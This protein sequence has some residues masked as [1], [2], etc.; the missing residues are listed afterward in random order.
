MLGF[1]PTYRLSHI[2]FIVEC[3][4]KKSSIVVNHNNFV[5]LYKHIATII[6]CDSA[7]KKKSLWALKNL[8][9]FQTFGSHN[10]LSRY[11]TVTKF[12]RCV[13]NLFGL[14][15]LFTEFKCYISALR[16]N[17]MVYF[18]PHALFSQAQ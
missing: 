12:S 8:I 15:T 2:I 4:T 14:T 1:V 16:S 6:L 17:D 3:N 10:F 18:S 13:D 11:G 9:I 5:I 7:C